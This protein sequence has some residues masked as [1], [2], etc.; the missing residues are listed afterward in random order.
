MRDNAQRDAEIVA[1]RESGKSWR[2]I[3]AE[4]HISPDRARQI[5]RLHFD[6]PACAYTAKVIP[7]PKEATTSPCT[8]CWP[9]WVAASRY[10]ANGFPVCI[11]CYGN[12]NHK[13]MLPRGLIQ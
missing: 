13:L 7:L 10:D 5:V 9:V 8:S 2:E 4:H 11:A 12:P 6:A 1:A 3:A